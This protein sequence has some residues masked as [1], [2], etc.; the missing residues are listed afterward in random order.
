MTLAPQVPSEVVDYY[1]SRFDEA[2]RLT[3]SGDGVLEMTRTQELLRRH[4]PPAPASVV[5]I[6]GGPGTHSRWLSRDGYQ[7]H[8]IDPVARHVEQAARDGVT[9]EIGD[10]RGLTAPDSSYDVALLM[11]P[12][13]HLQERADRVRALVEAYRVTR[14]G[15]LL[16]VA[17]INR[18]AP[19]FDQVATTLLAQPGLSERVAETSRTGLVDGARGFTRAYLHTV[20]ELE[21]E[22][23]AAGLSE[24][25]LYGVEGPGW[26]ILK[27]VELRAGEASADSSLFRAALVAARLAEEHPALLAASSH[28]LAVATRP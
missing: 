13:Y 12:L 19:I 22:M 21:D 2:G 3:S 16:A 18:Y 4:L 28:L 1:E 24:V 26:S 17:V 8:V 5:D 14:L 9:A 27:G 25:T 10:A 7:V 23:R 11:G 20:A 6:G 15:G